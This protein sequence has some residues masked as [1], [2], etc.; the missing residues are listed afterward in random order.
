MNVPF[1]IYDFICVLFPGILTLGFIYLE[2][3]FNSYPLEEDVIH[4]SPPGYN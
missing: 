1:K 2:T 3:P 4:L